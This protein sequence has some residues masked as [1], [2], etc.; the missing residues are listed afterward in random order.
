MKGLSSGMLAKMHE[1]GAAEAALGG[2]GR[3]DLEQDV[4]HAVNGVHVDARP[5][6]RHV[7]RGADPVGLRPAPRAAIP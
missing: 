7:D 4:A 5:A 6:R 3:G 2:R 1:L